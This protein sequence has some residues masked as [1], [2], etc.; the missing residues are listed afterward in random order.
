MRNNIFANVVFIF[1]VILLIPVFYF[2][3]IK[4]YR[5]NRALIDA[6]AIISGGA[7]ANMDVAGRV[8]AA[9]GDFKKA[10]K[11]N[12]LGDREAREQLAYFASQVAGSG[13][14]SAE[15][16][17]A[18]VNEAISAMKKQIAISPRDARYYLFLSSVYGAS[19]Q[20]QLARDSLFKALE[21]S[22]KKQQILFALTQGY[23]EENDIKKA[24]EFA[25]RA[26]DLDQ[27]YPA[28]RSNLAVLA[29]LAKD[30]DTADKEIEAL[31]QMDKADA[32]DFQKW[33]SVYA[34]AGKLGRAADFY[35]KAILLDPKNIQIRVSLSAVYFGLG[36]TSEAIKELEG[37]IAENPAFK[38][39]G[40]SIIQQ[41]RKGQRPF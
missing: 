3:N 24:M 11:L 36:K 5:A 2:T 32:A 13:A 35:K 10:L 23:F 38:E 18:I 12:T 4:P 30:F 19:G 27:T 33:G 21:F 37:A 34:S 22:P 41:I 6:I 39:Q 20:R 28:A 25:R 31:I 1:A 8:A 40:E 16:R 14:V 15:T 29:A 26:V 7:G 9:F 17:S